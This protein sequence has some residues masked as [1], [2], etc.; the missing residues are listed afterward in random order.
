MVPDQLIET[1]EE[2]TAALRF[3]EKPKE[4]D[5]TYKKEQAEDDDKADALYDLEIAGE[6]GDE[7][8]T[9]N[10]LQSDDQDFDE[11]SIEDNCNPEDEN[12]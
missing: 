12:G 1:P 7:F 4:Q 2:K 10:D 8:L 11:E 6:D 9:D 5:S 3:S